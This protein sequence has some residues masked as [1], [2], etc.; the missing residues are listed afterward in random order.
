MIFCLDIENR[1]EQGYFG[2]RTRERLCKLQKCLQYAA[3]VAD[4]KTITVG[5]FSV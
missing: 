3:Q 4:H 5:T 2:L 1:I